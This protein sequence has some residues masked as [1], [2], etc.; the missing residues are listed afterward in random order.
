MDLT[1]SRR[2]VAFDR[3]ALTMKCPDRHVVLLLSSALLCSSPAPGQGAGPP[4]PS[5]AQE[6]DPS[7]ESEP[8]EVTVQVTRSTAQPLA[9][10]ADAVSV[11]DTRT[12]RHESADLGEVLA[13]TRGVAVRR[14][15]GLGSA[16][17][18]SLNG[19]YDDQ[20]RFF[21]DGV[22]LDLTGFPFGIANVPVNLVQRVEVYRGV[23]PVALGA[24][25]LGGAV[26]LVSDSRFEDRV[27]GSYQLGS[28]GTHRATLDGRWRQEPTG[29][30]VGGA[31]FLDLARNDY[32][33]TVEV[34]D[35]RGRVR[36][37]NVRRFHDGYRA[38]GGTLEAG[39]VDQPWA[40]RL[41]LAGFAARYD[42]QLQHNL[43]MA[44][45]YGEVNYGE[46]VCGSTARYSVELAPGWG[47][48]LVAA[49]SHQIVRF[50]D[51]GEW[52]YD[53]YG[54]RIR[55]RPKPGEIDDATDQVQWQ[56]AGFGR[57]TFS[58]S[59]APEQALRLSL[60]PSYALRTGDE[61]IQAAPNQRDALNTR[62]HLF[63]LVSGLEHEL[64]L[65]GDRL[66]NVFFVKDY[67]YQSATQGTVPGG[68][69]RDRS[70]GRHRLGAGDALHVQLFPWLSAQ[71]S[72][73]YATRLPRPDEVFG[74]GVL[75]HANLELAPEVS[76][77]LNLGPRLELRDPALGAWLL[78]LNGFLRRAGQLIALL[79]NERFYTYR[80]VYA[81]RS[82]GVETALSWLSR[83]RYLNL[84]GALTW[85]DLRN[86]SRRGAFAQ[87]SGDRLPNRPYLFA[88][89]A[90]RL[91]FAGLPGPGDA[92]EPFYSGR[93]VHPFLRGWES[94]GLREFKQVIDSQLTHA[95]GLTWTLDRYPMRGA[96]TLEI[97]NVSDAKVFDNFGVQRPGRAFYLKVTA[98]R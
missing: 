20:I 76:H 71:A 37:A 1:A 7:L 50:V 72:Y 42:K 4:T 62:Q 82:L 98:E 28:F 31:A 30:V 26:Q 36:A 14:G 58:W 2:A 19:L 13:R 45:P 63:T 79:G 49:Y 55:Q 6:L 87:F 24:D 18:F 93:Y 43:V 91:R 85:Q 75:I 51:V 95:A 11:I 94:A 8:A 35:E 73:E 40:R 56:D 96:A 59:F 12:A 41:T 32:P 67:A 23:V 44:I 53:W 15:G 29:F 69:L 33:I 10:S 65:A 80:N 17:R 34:P 68:M 84:E 48:E 46:T 78:E 90:A 25:A 38:Y 83:G 74:D 22:P 77:N 52:V 47:L 61:R 89:W 64:Q 9:R 3:G 81:V 70:A 27:D 5:S 86:V 21:L 60:S 39:W 16:A 92:L 54:N 88:S 57:A 66:S 97:D